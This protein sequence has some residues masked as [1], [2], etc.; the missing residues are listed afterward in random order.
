NVASSMPGTRACVDRSIR[1]IENPSPTFSTC[2]FAVVSIRSGWT[3]ARPSTPDSAIEKQPACAAAISSSGFVP[4]ASS[5]R[6]PNEY[7][8]SY[9]PL[10]IRIVPF[11]SLNVPDHSAVADRTGIRPSLWFRVNVYAHVYV[12]EYVY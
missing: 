3:P 2:T 9:A 10:A 12:Y 5:K 4:G 6:D 7:R 8:P 1:V 11:P